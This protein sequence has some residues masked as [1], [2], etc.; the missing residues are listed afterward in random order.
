M[1]CLPL[2]LL[3][4]IVDRLNDKDVLSARRTCKMLRNACQLLKRGLTWTTNNLDIAAT[5]WIPR[6]LIIY[7]EVLWQTDDIQHI[8]HLCLI[9]KKHILDLVSLHRLESLY[10]TYNEGDE[11]DYSSECEYELCLPKNVKFV[12]VKSDVNFVDFSACRK[13]VY[14]YIHKATV[15]GYGL[16]TATHLIFS[17]VHFY[18]D[19][20]ECIKNVP[21]LE[22][23]NCSFNVV[24][25]VLNCK[26]LDA[27]NLKWIQYPNLPYIKRLRIIEVTNTVIV[28]KEDL[29][30][31][32]M[33]EIICLD[34]QLFRLS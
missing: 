28:R 8:T 25:K 7:P 4:L 6:P 24:P 5:P 14:A 10:V 9:G 23:F 19:E 21:V 29:R 32:E 22:F 1:E 30:Q 3:H 20:V 13:L 16:C 18:E 26:E 17:Y 15:G 33:L 27:R 31:C 11:D 34:Y 2:E 12:T